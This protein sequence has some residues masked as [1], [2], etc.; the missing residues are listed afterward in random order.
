MFCGK[1]GSTIPDG[2]VF[3]SNCG[4]SINDSS[5]QSSAQQST[6]SVQTVPVIM[7]TQPTTKANAAAITGFVFG[8]VAFCLC[9]IPYVGLVLGL[10]GLVLSIVG[11]NKKKECGRG[12]GLAIT[13]LLLSIIGLFM[14]AV[15][16]LGIGTYLNK[17]QEASASQSAY[18]SSVSASISKINEE[19]DR[20]M[21]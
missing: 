12:G 17:A 13:G 15:M 14:G 20:A 5:E 9:L 1:C 11:I 21:S 7:V 16:I 6:Q 3:C 19:I 8:I 4:A 2:N 18:E 10:V